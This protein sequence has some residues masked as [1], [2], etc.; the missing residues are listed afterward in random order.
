M[1]SLPQPD[2]R[3]YIG[4]GGSGKTT[5]ALHHADQF[6]RVII[7]DPNAETAYARFGRVLEDR[8]ELVRAAA[9]PSFRLTWRFD[10]GDPLEGYDWATRVAWAAG[11]CCVIWDEAENYHEGGRILPWGRRA[12]NQGRHRRLHVFAVTRS[13]FAIDR[14]LTRNVTRACIFATQEPRDLAWLDGFLRSSDAIDA[15]ATLPKYHAY[16]W[17]QGRGGCVKL[18]TFA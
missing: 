15:I 13:C 6:A 1:R 7:C 4:V 17:R 8:A 16:D 3:C 11:D 10:L 5:L 12:W 9:A 18:S 2:N 14:T